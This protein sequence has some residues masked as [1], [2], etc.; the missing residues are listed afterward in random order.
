MLGRTADELFWLS[1]YVERAEN[2]ARLAEV[3]YRSTMS[4]SPFVGQI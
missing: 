1:R 2:M 4:Y 3:G